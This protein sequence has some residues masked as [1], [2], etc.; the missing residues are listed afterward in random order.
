M[1]AAEALA[2]FPKGGAAGS[3]RSCTNPLPDPV[4]NSTDHFGDCCDEYGITAKPLWVLFTQSV[5]TALVVDMIPYLLRGTTN[6]FTW[7][8]MA[9]L[10]ACFLILQSLL[11]TVITYAIMAKYDYSGNSGWDNYSGLV[12]LWSN[13]SPGFMLAL[14][15]YLTQ[16]ESTIPKDS[17]VT[18]TPTRQ[19]NGIRASL[20]VV[21]CVFILNLFAFPL[22]LT[23]LIPGMLIW[24]PILAVAVVPAQHGLPPVAA[25]LLPSKEYDPDS[26]CYRVIFGLIAGLMN[27]WT[28]TAWVYVIRFLPSFFHIFAVRGDWVGAIVQDWESR[29]TNRFLECAEAQLNA[30]HGAIGVADV[31]ALFL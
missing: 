28:L 19:A 31:L 10:P 24:F 13:S 27:A 16:R 18:V 9:T 2:D 1:E 14:Q 21:F 7:G 29:S 23:H 8:S 26:L 4:T 30:D 12:Y 5:F 17:W 22:M 15:A 20:C 11:S 3:T 25:H 6:Y